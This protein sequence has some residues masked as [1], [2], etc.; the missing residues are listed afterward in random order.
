MWS[1]AALPL[2][3]TLGSGC[4]FS[5][6]LPD[7]AQGVVCSML[8]GGARSRQTTL[9]QTELLDILVY[10]NPTKG[11]FNL[12]LNNSNETTFSQV[13]VLDENLRTLRSIGTT[14]NI[15]NFDLSEYDNGIYFVHIQCK[16][17]VVVKKVVL[18]K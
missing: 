15:Y 18:E 14:Q 4:G 6:A 7:R 3:R 2:K 16:G 5:N 12:V 10:P 11:I 8:I 17:K 1:G 13:S 9:N